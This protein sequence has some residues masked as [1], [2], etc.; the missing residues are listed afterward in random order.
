MLIVQS[1]IA[2]FKIAALTLE[3]FSYLAGKWVIAEN[4]SKVTK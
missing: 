2:V 4:A 3:N 1:Q